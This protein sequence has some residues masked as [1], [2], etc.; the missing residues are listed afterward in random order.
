MS[1]RSI[2][3]YPA[4]LAIFEVSWI[5]GRPK[6]AFWTPRYEILRPSSLSAHC[7]PFMLRWPLL[8]RGGICISLVVT[9]DM[10]IYTSVY[11]HKSCESS[12]GKHYSSV[13][14]STKPVVIPIIFRKK[15]S[16][17]RFWFLFR[18]WLVQTSHYHLHKLTIAPK[19][20][21]VESFFQQ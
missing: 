14:Q 10:Q 3:N 21:W 9:K 6:R 8:R 4:N 18:N 16:G 7:A 20:F 2:P 1:V 19:P 15:I 12:Y 11:L 13:I 5:F 17:N